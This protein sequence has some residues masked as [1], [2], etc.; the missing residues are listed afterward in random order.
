ME[1]DAGSRSSDPVAGWHRLHYP[2]GVFLIVFGATRVGSLLDWSGRHRDAARMLGVGGGTVTALLGVSGVGELLLTVAAVLAVS[3]RRD[4][5]LLV[6]LAGWCA[7]FL[8][9]AVVT[10]IAADVARLVEHGVFLSAFGGLLAATYRWSGAARTPDDPDAPATMV[11]EPPQPTL[12]RL[13]APPGPSAV[14]A[15]PVPAPPVRP[16]VDVTR[17]DIR[18][19]KPEADGEKPQ[20][21]GRTRSNVSASESDVTDRDLAQPP[22]DTTHRDDVPEADLT[23]WDVHVPENQTADRDVAEPASD[24]TRQD[25]KVRKGGP[26][27]D[28][29][30]TR[31]DIPLQPRDAE[32]SAADEAEPDETMLDGDR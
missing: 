19:R 20:V 29:G 1:L 8:V 16:N 7:E 26:A 30:M 6:A 21:G 11:S 4:V 22:S 13:V 18:V 32:P 14:P 23:H 25:I 15:E 28:G 24:T 2:V 5:W 31:K 10:G 3:R 9:L 12:V 17:Q 27:D